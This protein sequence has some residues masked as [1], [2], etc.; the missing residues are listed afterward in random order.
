MGVIVTVSVAEN[1][2][3]GEMVIDRGKKNVIG[4]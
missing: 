2:P 3:L 4:A 1:A